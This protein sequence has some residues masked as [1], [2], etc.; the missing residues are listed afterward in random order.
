[1]ISQNDRL[2]AER[3]AD[4]LR[5]QI[6]SRINMLVANP[7]QRN[8]GYVQALQDILLL[9]NGT[10]QQMNETPKQKE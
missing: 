10:Y 6:D 7:D 4:E 2:L 8:A 9:V 3:L 5:N 1:M